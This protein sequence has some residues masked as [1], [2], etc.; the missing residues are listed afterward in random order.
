[1][2]GDQVS[3]ATRPWSWLTPFARE[4]LR[5]AKAVMSNW[6]L[7]PSTPRPILQDLLDI[8][9][10]GLGL[11]RGQL[12]HELRGEALVAGRDRRV[13]GEDGFGANL[14]EGLLERS[15]LGHQLARLLHEHE[16]GVALV[17]VPGCRGHAQLAQRTHAAHAEDE[18]LVQAHLTP[19]Y[20][21]DVADGP[22]ALDVLRHVG[23]EQQQGHAPD[24]H[25]PDGGVDGPAG[26]LHADGQRLAQRV[27]HTTQRQPCR[28]EV[29]VA[30]LLV[31][32]GVDV[33]AEVAAAVEE[34]YGHEGQGHVGGG[35]AV[36]A[37]E[38][39]E[40]TGVDGQ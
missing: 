4:V 22:V 21:E 14:R 16:R 11:R 2:M 23:V 13:D 32:V 35:L 20:I 38:H 6:L 28:I 9:A 8:D 36:V 37:G 25:Q 3:S 1:M 18:L 26:Q 31:A 19:A 5:S 40:A 7:L 17:E 29:E 30:V 12:A 39:A 10:R 33:L 27:D 34:A 15:T 24:L